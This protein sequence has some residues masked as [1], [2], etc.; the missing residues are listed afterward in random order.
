MFREIS[1]LKSFGPIAAIFII[2]L[3]L[4]PIL[5]RFYTYILALMFVTGLLANFIL[6]KKGRYLEILGDKGAWREG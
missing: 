5:P 4:P 2:L 3:I 1:N 6:L